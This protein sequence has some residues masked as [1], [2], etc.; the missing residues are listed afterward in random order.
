MKPWY[1]LLPFFLVLTVAPLRAE[2]RPL[3]FLIRDYYRTY[4]FICALSTEAERV[5]LSG[6]G[7]LTVP[8]GAGRLHEVRGKMDELEGRLWRLDPG[9][10]PPGPAPRAFNGLQTVLAVVSAT[11]RELVLEVLVARLSDEQNT[12]LIRLYEQQ[13]LSAQDWER[14]LD[15]PGTGSGHLEYHRWRLLGGSWY[16]D[17]A[18]WVLTR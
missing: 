16:R 7:Y 4:S 3:P 2:G 18:A 6:P 11:P 12:R 14:E 9:V 8:L 10:L 17:E 1:F 5:R 15:A 13:K